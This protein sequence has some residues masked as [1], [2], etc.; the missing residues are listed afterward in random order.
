MLTSVSVFVPILFLHNTAP[1]FQPL[2]HS[3][4]ALLALL[5]LSFFFTAA[6]AATEAHKYRKL[7]ACFLLLL[8]PLLLLLLLLV[9]PQRQ[10]C[11]LA[12]GSQ[13]R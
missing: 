7:A 4:P 3:T 5:P 1:F 9:L 11:L 10:Q 8:L 13:L 6:T 12:Q 2:S